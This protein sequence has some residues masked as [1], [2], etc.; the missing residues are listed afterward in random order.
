M[1]NKPIVGVAAAVVVIAAGTWFYLH[2]RHP[3]PSVPA[4]E[5]APA[6]AQPA[7]EPE[8]QHPLPAG[9]ENP[10]LKGPVPALA[11]SDPALLDALKTLVGDDAVKDYLRPESI[12]RHLVVTIDNLPRQKIAVEKR[13]T[14]ELAGSFLVK[15]DELHATL[16][17]Q[18]FA[19][20]QPMVAVI[21]KLDMQ[22]VAAVYVH[23]YPLFQE[24]YQDLG[25]PNGYFNDR[26]VQVIDSLLATPQP[27]A[28]IQ[29]VRPN[30]MYTFADPALESRPAGQKLLIRMGPDNAAAVKAKLTELR[31]AITAAPPKR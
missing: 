26:L 7:A 17:P 24:A 4:A 10:A 14:N 18:N 30:V 21:S 19:R 11:D 28:P 23:F 1:I 12:V 20:Y 15:G 29:L 3:L 16:D 13:P 31:A 27:A 8:I 6:P 25:Y 9:R 22:Q 5:Q 2:N